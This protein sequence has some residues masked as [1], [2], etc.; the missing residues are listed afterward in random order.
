[1]LGFRVV[2]LVPP[3][4]LHKGGGRR[5]VV[6]TDL[7][8][9]TEI[10]GAQNDLRRFRLDR[11]GLSPEYPQNVLLER[12]LKDSCCSSEN[13]REW[14]ELEKITGPIPGTH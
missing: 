14:I 12:D 4:R 5:R 11:V 7:Q 2:L 10:T 1:M 9:P 6:L 13:C 8:E 3:E